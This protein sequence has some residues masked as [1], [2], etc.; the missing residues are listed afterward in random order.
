MLSTHL[1]TALV[2]ARQTRDV[3]LPHGSRETG[4]TDFQPTDWQRCWTSRHVSPSDGHNR[5]LSRN[6]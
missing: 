5:H 6:V 4:S 1:T 3:A 2:H